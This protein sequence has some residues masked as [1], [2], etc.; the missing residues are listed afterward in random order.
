MWTADARPRALNDNERAAAD[1]PVSR[2]AEGCLCA[3][4]ALEAGEQSSLGGRPHDPG[5][6]RRFFFGPGRICC[7]AA[8]GWEGVL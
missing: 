4:K 7:V 8:S 5:L 6:L 2:L 1:A 3:H